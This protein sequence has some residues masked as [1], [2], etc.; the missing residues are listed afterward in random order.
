VLL[1]AEVLARCCCCSV[2]AV[3]PAAAA[4]VALEGS[5]WPDSFF[6]VFCCRQVVS[7]GR[8]SSTSECAIIDLVCSACCVSAGQIMHMATPRHLHLNLS[9]Q[10]YCLLFQGH[11]MARQ[12]GPELLLCVRL[13][14]ENYSACT[15]PAFQLCM[16]LCMQSNCCLLLKVGIREYMRSVADARGR[17]DQVNQYDD[18]KHLVAPQGIVTYTPVTWST[19]SRDHAGTYLHWDR[20][21]H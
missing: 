3:D 10:P 20:Q 9:A 2:A 5:Y 7:C 19:R 21:R 17:N 18:A 11:P 1:L 8:N 13:V 4:A 16:G 15:D 12:Q 14:K 6:L